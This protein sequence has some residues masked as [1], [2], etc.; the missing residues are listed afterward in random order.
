MKKY[1]PMKAAYSESKFMGFEQNRK[2]QNTENGV[3]NP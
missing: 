1:K 3:L 2:R